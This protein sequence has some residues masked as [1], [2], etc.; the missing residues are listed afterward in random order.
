MTA[1]MT[2]ATTTTAG[3][4]ANPQPTQT[5]VPVN[6]GAA[7]FISERGPARW[8]S[9]T[10][11]TDRSLPVKITATIAMTVAAHRGHWR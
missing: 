7:V 9:K 10:A 11:E 4:G 1:G 3:A 8:P 2:G 5:A 6:S